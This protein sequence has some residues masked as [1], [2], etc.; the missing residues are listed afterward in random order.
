MYEEVEASCDQS[1]QHWWKQQASS[2]L[3][4]LVGGGN[5]LSTDVCLES[6]NSENFGDVIYNC[7]SSA[8]LEFNELAYSYQVNIFNNKQ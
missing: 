1:L 4:S 6:M 3:S 7:K 5:P 8:Q 2:I